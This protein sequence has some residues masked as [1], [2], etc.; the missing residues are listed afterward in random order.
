MSEQ[1]KATGWMGKIIFS[2]FGAIFFIIGLLVFLGILRD[3]QRIH[4]M[5]GWTPAPCQIEES[6]VKSRGEG[7]YLEVAYRYS[8]EGH[9]YRGTRFGADENGSEYT[10]SEWDRQQKNY[11]P[12]ASAT[13]YYNPENPAESVLLPPG[14]NFWIYIISSLFPLLGLFFAIIP[15]LG[16]TRKTKTETSSKKGHVFQIMGIIFLVTGTVT[17]FPSFLLPLKQTVAAKNWEKTE[18]TVILSKI[19]SHR[20]DETTTYRP[21]IA[22][23]Y[24]LGGTHYL[25]DRYSFMQASSSEYEKKRSI[26][27]QYPVG[28][29]FF[30]YV[31]PE[32]PFESVILRDSEVSLLVGLL[33]LVFIV[34]GLV[35][36]VFDLRSKRLNAK[37]FSQSVVVL[38]GGSPLWN[39]LGTLLLGTLFL[40]LFFFLFHRDAPSLLKII[41]GLFS[42][43]LLCIAGYRFLALFNPR[44]AVEIAPGSI[45]PGSTF[46]LR[47]KMKGQADRLQDLKISLQCEKMVKERTHTSSGTKTIIRKV[48]LYLEPIKEISDPFEMA[49]GTLSLHIPDELPASKP[50][51]EDGI[52]WKIIFHGTINRWPDL[53]Q[54]SPFLVYPTDYA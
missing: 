8:V 7:F 42:I 26:V 48:S 40:G 20:S 19:I 10:L 43:L 17:L 14:F 39:F 11:P 23:R 18:A 29:H 52:S 47:W 4:D 51:F 28:R 34:V 30:I 27:Q 21:Y 3:S 49:Q 31:N 41:S 25:G 1:S 24:T 5:Q 44:P 37:Q 33:P 15:W 35:L 2:L 6:A 32:D 54:T 13:C 36:I 22:Y 50:G 53:N 12:N 45:Y 9:S 46:S 38:K 16:R